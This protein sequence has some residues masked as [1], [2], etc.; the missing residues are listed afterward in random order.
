MAGLYAKIDAITFNGKEFTKVM[1]DDCRKLI[2]VA[3]QKWLM[4]VMRRIPVRTGFLQGAFTT[5]ENLVGTVN[6]LTGTINPSRNPLLTREKRL[7]YL[8]KKRQTLL[9]SMQATDTHMNDLI[10]E[11]SGK[12]RVD[13]AAE[14]KSQAFDFQAKQRA[15]RENDFVKAK[16]ERLDRAINRLLGLRNKAKGGKAQFEVMRRLESLRRKREKAG[17]FA[18]RGPYNP[19]L[20]KTKA[21]YTR[22]YEDITRKIQKIANQ[23]QTQAERLANLRKRGER[24]KQRIEEI[25]EVIGTHRAAKFY[26]GGTR[27]RAF[28]EYYYYPGGKILK[29]PRSGIP[30]ATKEK[31]IFEEF[32]EDEKDRKAASIMS[33]MQKQMA[34]TQAFLQSNQ[35]KNI[36]GAEKEESITNQM[37]DKL[38]TK[39]MSQ[40]K[41][42]KV[43]FSFRF[44]VN[45]IYWA[46]NDLGTNLSGSGKK[47]HHKIKQFNKVMKNL[48]MN[49]GVLEITKQQSIPWQSLMAGNAAF[50]Q[51][52]RAATSNPTEFRSLANLKDFLLTRKVIFNGSNIGE[53]KNVLGAFSGTNS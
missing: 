8:I 28:T 39:A 19:I 26:K 11:R 33:E 45:I 51:F 25:D 31:D 21:R 37:M 24:I 49:A 10:R 44:E 12:K 14:A 53:V 52:I 46:V 48:S 6:K 34:A 27:T 3:A 43:F 16:I 17:Y 30:F 35:G 40:M 15:E 23:E 32:K 22:E 47:F 41:D 13:L 42:S 38:Y 9:K 7:D 5:L 50:N 1:A 4:A 29:T 2:R 36:R 20:K 18:R